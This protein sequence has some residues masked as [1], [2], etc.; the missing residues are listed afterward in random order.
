[1]LRSNS[2]LSIK[3][4]TGQGITPLIP[5]V[6]GLR[7]AVFREWSYLYEGED[8]FERDCLRTCSENPD[9]RF[10]V[11]KAGA[12]VV[13]ISTGIPPAAEASEV[14]APFLTDGI[15]PESIFYFGESVFLP[16]WWRLGIGAVFLRN[17]FDGNLVTTGACPLVP[18]AL[19]IT[20]LDYRAG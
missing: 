2:V 5:D 8:A 10:V 16:A 15:D 18:H 6:A 9:S 4:H 3:C 1:M 14:K 12:G 19:G 7:I 20:R 11:T 13:G 17:G